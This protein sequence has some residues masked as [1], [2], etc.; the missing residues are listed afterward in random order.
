MT[1]TLSDVLKCPNCGHE[2]EVRVMQREV[3][4]VEEIERALMITRDLDVIDPKTLRNYVR[5]AL[6]LPGTD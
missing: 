4:T 1:T 5:R 3:K 6:G 2:K